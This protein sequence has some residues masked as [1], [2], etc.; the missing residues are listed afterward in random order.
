MSNLTPSVYYTIQES[1]EH[2]IQGHPESPNRLKYLR[3]WLENPPYPGMEYLNF[4]PADGA[5][6]MLVHHSSLI[7]HINAESQKGSHTVESAPTYVAKNTYADALSAVGAT[8]RI[9]REIINSGTGKGFAIVRPPGHHADADHSMG[10]CIFNNTALA[11]ADAI[12]LGMEKVAIVDFD[13][14]HGNGTQDIFRNTPGVGFLS[15]H[16][17][18]SY[19]GTGHLESASDAAGR[20]VN[21]PVPA[22]SGKQV[23]KPIHEEIIFPWLTKFQPEMIFVS[24]GYDGHFSD[25]LTTLTLDTK[26]YYLLTQ[27]LV[28]W[29]DQYCDGRIMYILEGGYDPLALRDNI[30]ASL[31]A[32]CGQDDYPDHYGE[33]LGPITEI[34]ELITTI[35]AQHHL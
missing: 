31:A 25:P 29:A 26:F 2:R 33:K 30:Q 4:A 22:F 19:P 16:E 13:A 15:T 5:D 12:A 7:D 1:P 23:F 8:L 34:G 3:E 11:A 18:R 35:K 32:M 21:V 9:S 6:L 24:A 14:H 17:A 10:F 27:K 28:S 20:I